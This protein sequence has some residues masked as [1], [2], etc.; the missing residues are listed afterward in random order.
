MRG[1]ASSETLP[2]DGE[3]PN[4]SPHILTHPQAISFALGC[5]EQC[6]GRVRWVSETGIGFGEWK[7]PWEKMSEREK[8]REVLQRV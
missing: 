3:N 7:K 8:Q 1:T 5:V 2:W 6:V 4:T